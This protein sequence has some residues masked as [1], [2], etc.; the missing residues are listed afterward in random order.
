MASQSQKPK[1]KAQ[2]RHVPGPSHRHLADSF[3]G[4]CGVAAY[5]HDSSNERLNST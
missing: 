3:V 1:G 4:S 5:R 2:M